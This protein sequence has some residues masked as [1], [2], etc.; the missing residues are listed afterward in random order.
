MLRVA[1]IVLILVTGFDLYALDGRYSNA[2][3]GMLYSAF[4]HFR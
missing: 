4:Q 1:A 3:G 2:A